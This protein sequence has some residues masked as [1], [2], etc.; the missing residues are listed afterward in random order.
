M[1]YRFSA[2][3]VV[4]AIAAGSLADDKTKNEVVKGTV[5]S[6]DMATKTI[7]L[8]TAD[9]EKSYVAEDNL[10]IVFPGGQR[11]EASLK[12]GGA[13][14]TPAKPGQPMQGNPQALQIAL[15]PGNE[16]QLILSDK[17]QTVKEV[18][19]IAKPISGNQQLQRKKQQAY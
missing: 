6:F 19:M 13:A 7:K 15:R 1:V 11:L 14:K 8:K 4:L 12:Q 17:D 16:V 10:L 3:A 5:V 18:H 2:L 9:A